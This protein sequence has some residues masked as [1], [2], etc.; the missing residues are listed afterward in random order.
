MAQV[1]IG[2]KKVFNHIWHAA[3]FHILD[4]YGI[5]TKLHN[6]IAN[7]YRRAVTT[8]KCK[9]HVGEWFRITVGSRQGCILSPDLF[10]PLYWKHHVTCNGQDN[11]SGC[12]S[13]Q[14]FIQQSSIC[15]W[16]CLASRVSRQFAT[17]VRLSQ[18]S[19]PCIW[20]GD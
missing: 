20:H 13:L 2:Y 7:L 16:Y 5:P 1:F 19:K 14:S 18:L 3:L 8:V 4:H 12:T 9:G 11:W 10:K 17:P 6:H 15:Y